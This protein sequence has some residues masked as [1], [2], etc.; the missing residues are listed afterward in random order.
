MIYCIDLEK[1]QAMLLNRVAALGLEQVSLL[2]SWKRVLAQNINSQVNVPTFSRSP[3]DGYAVQIKDVQHAS[4]KKPAR[5]NVL[6]TLQAGTVFTG[7]VLQGNAVRIMTGAPIPKGANGVIRLED[8]DGG[9]KIVEI[10]QPLTSNS[11]IIP[12]GEDVLAGEQI[13]T[14]G[15]VLSSGA[16]GMLAA[17]GQE[18][19]PVYQQ[20]QIALFSTGEELVDVNEPLKQGRIHNSNYYGL[21]GAI[22]EAG[23]KPVLLGLTGDSTLKIAE[24]LKLGLR[25]SGLV[26]ST[27]GASV[28][29][30]DLMQAA[31]QE[32]GAKI[33]FWRMA[34]RP[35]AQVLAAEK[36]GKLLIGLSGNP[37][38]AWITFELLVRP[39]IRKLA[40]RRKWLR[41]SYKA[42]AEE[43][44]SKC[45]EIRRFIWGYASYDGSCYRV[46]LLD[47]QNPG[48]LKSILRCNALVDLP[49][50]SSTIKAGQEVEMILL[51]SC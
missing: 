15:E 32:I 24:K 4:A 41:T 19:V 39:L 5:L 17:I 28:G 46:K 23:G 11:N 35:G 31:Y 44:Y 30:Y 2:E 8:T 7:E 42:I 33:L 45:G 48:I 29:D 51:N 9:F 36:D 3:L 1:A 26:I 34:V 27:G 6:G 50:N 20:P 14:K 37:S 38:A 22:L 12:A 25:E 10:Y 40:G 49:A 47:K 21:A 18:I 13:L 43:D 16:I